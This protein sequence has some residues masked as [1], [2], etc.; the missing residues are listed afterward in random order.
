MKAENTKTQ[1]DPKSAEASRNWRGQ[2]TCKVINLTGWQLN[3]ILIE[4][5]LGAI[6]DVGNNDHIW[7]RDNDSFDFTINVGSGHS[8]YWHIEAEKSSGEVLFRDDKGC[9][10]EYS[11]W[12]SGLPMYI[13]IGPRSPG[14][15]IQLPKSSSC[16][17][18]YYS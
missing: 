2:M 5:Y 8:D 18:N 14:F 3:R 9:D 15:S 13:I 16:M 17:G 10:V 4:H 6:T 11:D 7:M 12:D 1:D